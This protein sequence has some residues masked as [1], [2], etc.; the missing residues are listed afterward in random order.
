MSGG[1]ALNQSINGFTGKRTFMIRFSDA[2]GGDFKSESSTRT[3]PFIF[4]PAVNDSWE[5]DTDHKILHDHVALY[6]D[7]PNLVVDNIDFSYPTGSWETIM[8]VVNYKMNY[9]K[10]INVQ[11]SAEVIAMDGK[12]FGYK[13]ESDSTAINQTMGIRMPVVKIEITMKRNKSPLLDC[14]EYIGLVNSA[15]FA[16]VPD[17]SGSTN[18]YLPY[19]VFFDGVKIVD[20]YNENGKLI[21]KCTYSFLVRSLL[22]SE[23]MPDGAKSVTWQHLF[24]VEKATPGWELVSPA[25]YDFADLNELLVP[26]EEEP[27]TVP[28]P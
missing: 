10:P 2:A 25:M 12:K 7:I 22:L 6:D 16:P 18:K 26:D 5:L 9:S 15:E 27:S 20:S 3:S 11:Y 21:L 23:A 14:E 4:L 1:F 13:W 17:I 28:P 24:R 19:T 8:A